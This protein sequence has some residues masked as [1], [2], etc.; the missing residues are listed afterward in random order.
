MA[1]VLIDG[2]ALGDDS[3]YRGVGTYLSRLLAG[4]AAD[5][6]LSVSTLVRSG[7]R[8]PVGIEPVTV[9]RLA[10]PRL[11]V[12]EH[13]LLLPWDLRRRRVDVLHSPALNP[14][15]RYRGRWVQ[16][17]HDVI[18]LVVADPDLAV[19]RRRWRR[20]A[21][22]YRAAD[23][24]VAVS[25]HT[26]R[27]G[28]RLL[29]LDPA[30]VQV[31]PH[32]VGPEFRP[33]AARASGEPPYLLTVGEY[34][35]RKGYPEAFAVVGAL[36]DA[37]YPHRLRVAGR[38][39]PW[40]RPAIE[41]VVMRADRPDRIDLLGFVDDLVV[42]Y[43]SASVVLVPSRYE[44]FG[45]PIIEAMACGTPV[46]AFDNSAIGEAV[47]DAGL[48]VADGDVAAMAAAVRSLLDDGR[49]WQD[50]SHRG[51][52]RARAFTWEASAAAHGDLYLQVAGG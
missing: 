4:L 46:V 50:Y 1:K 11:R 3:A 33:P 21:P 31:I 13:D 17:L 29:G 51:L 24:I 48:L 22:R 41:A 26:A 30:R 12:A 8:L 20:Y 9:P 6:R 42:Q 36:A 35:R 5:S 44:G 43:Q 27:E 14:P 38:I 25:R 18:P 2:T 15:R 19:E 47:G 34:S 16:T 28:I 32:G 10:P 45:L 40:V 49:R 52:E 23:A 37:G 39:A 7:T